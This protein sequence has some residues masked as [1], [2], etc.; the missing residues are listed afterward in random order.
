MCIGE[1]LFRPLTGETTGTCPDCNTTVGGRVVGGQW[2]V[3]AA[4]RPQA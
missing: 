4:H 3:L 1:G 2:V